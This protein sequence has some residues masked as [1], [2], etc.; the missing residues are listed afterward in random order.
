MKLTKR[1]WPVALALFACAYALNHFDW[2]SVGD[3]LPRV[4]VIPLL[5]ETSILALAVFTACALRWVAVNGMPWRLSEVR[6]VYV[7][8]SVVIGASIA[9]PLQL[10]EILKLKFA[11]DAGLP[12]GSSVVNLALERIID[13]SAIAGMTIGGLAYAEFGSVLVAIAAMA[14]PFAAGLAMPRFVHWASARFAHTWI[15]ARLTAVSGDPLPANA[16]MIIAL[17]TVAKWALT[18]IAWTAIAGAVGVWLTF[19]QGMLLVGL[20][21]MVSLLSMIPAGIGV[22][23]VSVR[24]ILIAMKFDPIQAETAAILLRIFTPVVVVLGLAHLPFLMQSRPVVRIPRMT[25]RT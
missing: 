11:R 19:P 25:E 21:T 14:I 15:G 5:A 20:V 23:E 4:P 13:L 9:T 2:R 6:G 17:C 24:A 22:Q 8:V 3:A 1:W 10:G 7:Y 12:L 16:L 18:L